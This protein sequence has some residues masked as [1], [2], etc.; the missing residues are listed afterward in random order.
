[1]LL[2]GQPAAPGTRLREG[3]VLVWARPPWHEPDVPLAFDVLYED[4]AL[5]VVDKP[6]GLPTLPGG[7]EFL[8]HTLLHQV[9]ER[10]GDVSPLHRLDRGTS[11][12]VVFARTGTAASA[13]GRQWQ[14]DATKVYCARVATTPAWSSLDIDLPIGDVPHP[15]MGRV[16]AVRADGRPS[17]TRVRRDDTDPTRIE[18]TLVTGRPHQIRIHLAAVGHP[19][20]GEPFYAAGGQPGADSQ[21]V[22]DTGFH[23]HAWHVTFAHP[24]SGTEITVV[25]PPPLW[26]DR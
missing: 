9:R 7:G 4:E 21:R 13:L 22:S 1:M 25:A 2:D 17:R 8:K 24:L 6:A 14:G 18:A 15:V 11:G 12:I 23:L 20:R 10:H 5:L 26:A 3:Q 19:L 16:A